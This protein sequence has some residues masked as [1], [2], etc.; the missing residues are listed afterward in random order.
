MEA[1][2]LGQG[3]G[4]LELISV[5]LTNQCSKA[6]S[7]CYNHS[8]SIGKTRFA[9]RDVVDLATSCA[10]NGVRAISLGGGE[11]LEYAGVFDILDAL[12]GTMFRTLTTNGLPLL[13][14]TT[15][16]SLV[17][18]SPDKVHVSIHFPDRQPEVARVIRQVTELADRGIRSGVNLVVRRSAL[19][20]ARHASDS[21]REAGI[22][23]DRI[24]YLPMR[25]AD[26][27]TP[28]DVALVAGERKFQSTSCL[29]ACAKSP[30]F[31][32]IAW[33]RSVAWCSYTT[34]RRPL[35]ALTHAALLEALDGL[36]LLRCGAPDA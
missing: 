23:V 26:E 8:S 30:R 36:P 16:T 17:A 35:T 21:L 7:F 33:D 11:P 13:D 2:P 20:A 24:A 3:P 32:S 28:Q 29:A 15:M 19:D 27:P 12:R 10:G 5:E 34:S 4:P 18:S 22:G 1:E 9:A 14:E 31:C 6:C 25:M